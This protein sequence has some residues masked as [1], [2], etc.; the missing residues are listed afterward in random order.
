M[1]DLAKALAATSV[2]TG[3]AT[4]TTIAQGGRALQDAAIMLQV[5]PRARVDLG[6]QKVPFGIEGFQSS[7]SLPVIER[8]LF[9]SDRS[10]GGS[11]GDVRDVGLSVRGTLP[12]RID[13]QVGAFNGSGESQNDVDANLAKAVA[14]HVAFRPFAA[15]LLGASAVSGGH[16]AADA[17][18]R[19]RVGGELRVQANGIL[20]QGEAVTGHDGTTIR[21]GTYLHAGYR[22]RPALDLHARFDAWD[23]DRSREADAASATER[24]YITGFTWTIPRTSLKAQADGVRRTYSAALVPNRWQLFLNLQTTW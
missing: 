9:A 17:P 14:A 6:Q 10:R 21:R 4:R 2:T 23:P 1:L 20:L 24:D 22:A 12:G 18:K 11:F 5:H 19:D 8:A 15:L 3:P 13:Y 16:G 7:G